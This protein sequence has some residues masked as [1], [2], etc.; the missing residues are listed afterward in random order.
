MITQFK[1]SVEPHI[2]SLDSFVHF[3]RTIQ[4][5]LIHETN[6]RNVLLAEGREQLCSHL[7]NVSG[8]HVIGVARWQI[9]NRD[10]DLPVRWSCGMAGQSKARAR[11]QDYPSVHFAHEK[12]SP[13]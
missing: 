4:L 1:A 7:G 5:F 9:V 2:E 6:S 12:V 11:R 10:R 8:G 3:A 13:I